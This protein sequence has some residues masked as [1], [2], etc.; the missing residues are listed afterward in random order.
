MKTRKPPMPRRPPLASE[1][2]EAALPGLAF[3]ADPDTFVRRFVL[4]QVLAPPPSARRF[5]RR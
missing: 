5:R 4:S 3:L 1:A 2:G